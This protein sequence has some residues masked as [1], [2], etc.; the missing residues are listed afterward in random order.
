MFYTLLMMTIGSIESRPQS[1]LGNEQVIQKI[2]KCWFVY[3]LNTLRDVISMNFSSRN[4]K[5]GSVNNV[6]PFNV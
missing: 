6:K 2:L 1:A 3:E 5:L 4:I